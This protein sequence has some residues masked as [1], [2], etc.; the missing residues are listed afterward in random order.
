MDS[1]PAK[2]IFRPIKKQQF[3]NIIKKQLK[4]NM[5]VIYLATQLNAKDINCEECFPYLTKIKPM[6]FYTQVEEPFLAIE[7]LAGNKMIWHVPTISDGTNLELEM[8]MSC[9][10]GKIHCFD[11]GSRNFRAHDQAM[12]VATYQFS[13]CDVLHVYTAFTEETKAYLRRASKKPSVLDKSPESLKESQG[14]PNATK[15]V[16]LRHSLAVMAIDHVSIAKKDPVA[17][18]GKVLNRTKL[19]IPSPSTALNVEYINKVDNTKGLGVTLV[20]SAGPVLLEIRYSK[21]NWLLVGAYEGANTYFPRD[22][23]FFDKSFSLC[24]KLINFYSA[25]E[26]ILSFYDF[27]IDIVPDDSDYNGRSSS[28]V[29]Q[30]CWSCSQY[31]TPQ[32]TQAVFIVSFI[33]IMLTIGMSLIWSIGKNN[34]MQN[35]DEPPLHIKSDV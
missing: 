7:A 4:T 30:D 22:L 3:T 26:G 18:S 35:L 27:N 25:A 21:G 13:E 9:E 20:T 10:V 23:I 29:A 14:S 33:L 32:L 11:L 6:N 1:P 31:L 2:S 8:E 24:C 19:T 12:A 28:Y 17:F 5:V 15:L 16:V 34:F